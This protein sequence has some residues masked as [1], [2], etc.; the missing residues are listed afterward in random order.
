[1]GHFFSFLKY[2]RIQSSLECV[3]IHFKT[4][5][6]IFGWDWT[7]ENAGSLVKIRSLLSRRFITR[8]PVLYDWTHEKPFD[9][10]KM[11]QETVGGHQLRC[12]CFPKRKKE[13]IL[14]SLLLFFHGTLWPSIE[15]WREGP[16]SWKRRG[17][18]RKKKKNERERKKNVSAYF[19]QR[20]N[21]SG[22]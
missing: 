15:L 18:Q 7:V 2:V 3:F 8:L 16:A 19:D 10:R 11:G 22:I 9:Q 12:K 20:K 5:T 1:M 14:L 4:I 17:H 13:N 21:V 6:C